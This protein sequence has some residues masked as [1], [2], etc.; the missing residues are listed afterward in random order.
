M[1]DARRWMVFAAL[2]PLACGSAVS[3]PQSPGSPPPDREPVEPAP[4]A[5][6]AG[7]AASSDASD[8]SEIRLPSVRF[9]PGAVEPAGDEA[10]AALDR[11]A[12][13]LLR[14]GSHLER[15]ELAGH[16]DP[17]EPDP[18]GTAMARAEAVAR[19]LAARGVEPRRLEPRGYAAACPL[20]DSDSAAAASRNARVDPCLPVDG[21]C[22]LYDACRPTVAE[23]SSSAGAWYSVWWGPGELQVATRQASG[24]R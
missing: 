24:A 9:A 14:E 19:E 12:E 16:A 15:V 3:G 8:R 2:A 1:S 11:L 13:I 4:P 21:I 18:A 7:P 5:P 22:P 6:G 20:D 10:L 17:G 23:P